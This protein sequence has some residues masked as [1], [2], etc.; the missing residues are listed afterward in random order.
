[1]KT[2]EIFTTPVCHYCH[3]AK[4]FMNAN[5]IEFTQYDVTK[6]LVR[7]QEL[8]DLGAMGV[9]LIRITGEGQEPIIMNGFGEDEAETLSKEFHVGKYA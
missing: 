7:R 6:D 3:L 4:E 9:P 5:K 1:M 2:V 8:I